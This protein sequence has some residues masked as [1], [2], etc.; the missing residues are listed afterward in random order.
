MPAHIFLN[1]AQKIQVIFA[2][3]EY[4][5]TVVAAIIKVIILVRQKEC[6]SAGHVLSPVQTSEV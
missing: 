1:L 2:L 3:K 6:C 4:G 5:L